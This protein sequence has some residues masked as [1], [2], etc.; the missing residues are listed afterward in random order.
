MGKGRDHPFSQGL[1]AFFALILL[2]AGCARVHKKPSPP[3]FLPMPSSFSAMGYFGYKDPSNSL[4]GMWE[5]EYHGDGNYRLSLYSNIGTLEAC[6]SVVHGTPRPCKDG[7]KG[8]E[9]LDSLPLELWE[10]LPR[11]LL[12]RLKGFQVE[13]DSK[14]RAKE[15]VIPLRD[16][17]LWR[18]SFQHYLEAE[19][20]PYPT[21]V[22]VKGEQVSL[23]IRI[24]EMEPGL[25]P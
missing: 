9:V 24:E 23:N 7:I 2:L 15:A 20:V 18:V 16:R 5:L 17:G 11:I 19:G 8:E 10:L 12:G 1:G 6:L 14:G 25:P 13:L 4:H 21:L 3:S 22:K